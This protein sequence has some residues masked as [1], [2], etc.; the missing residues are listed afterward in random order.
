MT[1]NVSRFLEGAAPSEKEYRPIPDKLTVSDLLMP[2]QECLVLG[3]R[4]WH[5]LRAA[6]RNHWESLVD[7]PGF[8]TCC[9]RQCRR[10]LAREQV[11]YRCAWMPAGPWARWWCCYCTCSWMQ[12]ERLLDA[13]T[14]PRP[15]PH[16]AQINYAINTRKFP[17]SS[18]A[19]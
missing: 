15:G 14:V 4:E 2:L 18:A 1:N 17:R 7:R 6:S 3:N 19:S 8:K 10:P 13:R 9:S 12:S 5:D 16:R 11:A